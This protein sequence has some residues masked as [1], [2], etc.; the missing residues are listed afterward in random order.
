MEKSLQNP[1]GLLNSTQIIL[2]CL[3]KTGMDENI[4]QK[5]ETYFSLAKRLD[6]THPKISMIEMLMNRVMKQY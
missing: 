2:M 4:F 6:K 3:E 5:A 1:T